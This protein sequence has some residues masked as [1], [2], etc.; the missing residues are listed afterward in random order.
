MPILQRR[1]D[2]SLAACLGAGLARAL[3]ATWR[4]H[5]IDPTDVDLGVRSGSKQVIAAFW[6]Q[7]ILPVLGHFHHRRI[8]VPVSEHRD[9]EYVAHIMD[10]VGLASVRGSTTRGSIKLLRGIMARMRE[11]WSIAVTPDG[12]RGP[13]F[14]VQ[15]GIG[16]LARRSGLPVHPL[17]VAAEHAWTANSWDRFVIPKPWTRLTIVVGEPLYARDFDDV[18]AFCEALLNALLATNEAARQAQRQT[19]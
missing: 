8:C 4:V 3:H 5:L 14:S 6:H 15:P 18:P 17:G 19:E 16:L 12:P 7:H 11:G 1:I 13:R 2:L 9:G 10:R